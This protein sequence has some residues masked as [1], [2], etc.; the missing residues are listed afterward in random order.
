MIKWILFWSAVYIA[1]SLTVPDAS[2]GQIFV[3]YVITYMAALVTKYSSQ[4]A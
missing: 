3:L 4:E 1:I 2:G